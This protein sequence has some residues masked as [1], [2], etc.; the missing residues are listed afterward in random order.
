MGE[1]GFDWEFNIGDE[2]Q[3][4]DMY[5]IEAPGAGR[6]SGHTVYTIERRLTDPDTEE[7]FYYLSYEDGDNVRN[8]LKEAEMTHDIY[9]KIS[10]EVE[11]E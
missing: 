9:E 10:S 4:K 6:L 7:H 3:E 8:T 11:M 2:L 5:S 1:S